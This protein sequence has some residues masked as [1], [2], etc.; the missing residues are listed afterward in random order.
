[1]KRILAVFLFV[2]AILNSAPDSFSECAS[3]YDGYELKNLSVQSAAKG[4]V[5]KTVS[6]SWKNPENRIQKISLFDIGSDVCLMISDKIN[7]AASAYVC[8]NIEYLTNGTVYYFKLN[9]LIGDGNERNY[10][11]SASPSQ[12]TNEA[13]LS[14]GKHSIS[15]ARS[16]AEDCY[17]AVF[18]SLKTDSLYDGKNAIE[19]VSNIPSAKA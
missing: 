11:V 1:M 4:S 16:S 2:F 19:A 12:G 13:V 15:Y 3:S 7:T 17:P 18:Y 14:D 5:G 9:V 10:F 6:I 8:E